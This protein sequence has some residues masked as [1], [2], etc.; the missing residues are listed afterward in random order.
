MSSLKN[1]LPN[2]SHIYIE[3]DAYDYP[4]TKTILSRYRLSRVI[5]INHYKEIFNRSNQNF[6]LQKSSMKLIL[7]VK[8]PP[9]LYPVSPIVQEFDSSK[10]YYTTPAINCLYN[11][12]YCFLQGMYPSG[13]LVLFVNEIDFFN[14]VI[15]EMKK[16]IDKKPF[17]LS[18]SYNTD[19]MAMENIV[20]I[21]RNW[22]KF[23]ETVNDLYLEIRTKS[24]LFSSISDICSNK[25]T[26][27]SWT[28]SPESVAKK[29]EST[30]P[31][32]KSRLKSIISAIDNGWKVRICFDPVLTVDDWQSIYTKFF[33]DVFS[34]IKPSSIY[35]TT[36][37][38]FRMNKEHFSRIKKTDINSDL[39][40]HKYENQ[41]GTL[42]LPKKDL[43]N[44]INSLRLELEKYI[45]KDKIHS[46]N[47]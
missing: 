6:Q 33:H 11:C 42:S 40:F 36:I 43:N 28:L 1:T 5:K 8:P 27:L 32:L 47:V 16:K 18:I 20:P 10:V 23:S 44:V 26:I 22:I 25:N 9:Y 19:L 41:D 17:Y 38:V 13:N 14:S 21:C 34:K 46:W 30:A 3:K 29:Y 24:G 2:L 39:Y 12:E 45:K 4:L 31:P 37:G 7:A 15:S 35:D